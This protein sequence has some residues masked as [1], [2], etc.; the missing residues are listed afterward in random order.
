MHLFPKRDFSHVAGSA[1]VA[2]VAQQVSVFGE[3]VDVVVFDSNIVDD[4][5]FFYKEF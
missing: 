4:D 2:C 3:V 5:H 1:V